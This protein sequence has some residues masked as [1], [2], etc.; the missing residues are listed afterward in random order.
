MLLYTLQDF[1]RTYSTIFLFMFK[2]PRIT[3]LF[4]PLNS[5]WHIIWNQK[6]VQQSRLRNMWFWPSGHVTAIENLMLQVE[7]LWD[8]RQTFVKIVIY[9]YMEGKCSTV[10]S[11]EMA[12]VLVAL[13]W[14]QLYW[15]ILPVPGCFNK[16]QMNLSKNFPVCKQK[17][18]DIERSRNLRLHKTK[19]S[20]Y[21]C[22]P[23]IKL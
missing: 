18:K 15:Y 3:S 8:L 19:K 12:T 5:A 7:T 6:W 10:P 20:G 22:I 13:R 11:R 17:K 16:E 1:V 9:S 2:L 4:P 21:F 23:R 14:E